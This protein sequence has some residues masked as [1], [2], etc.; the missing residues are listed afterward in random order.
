M[1]YHT[2]NCSWKETLMG[3]KISG[4]K[5]KEIKNICIVSKISPSRYVLIIKEKK[6]VTL[7]WRSSVDNML[8]IWS[9]LTSSV[10]RHVDI[11]YVHSEKGMPFVY[12]SGQKYITSI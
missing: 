9:R 12:D 4:W 7:Q 6:I 10:L 11:V 2:N 1:E 5:Y 3:A 8:M